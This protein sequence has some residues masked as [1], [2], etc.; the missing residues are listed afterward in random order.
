MHFVRVVLSVDIHNRTQCPGSGSWKTRKLQ[1]RQN[2]KRFLPAL[3][4]S[5]VPEG[6]CFRRAL[7]FSEDI[8]TAQD[9]AFPFEHDEFDQ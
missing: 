8:Q 9:T 1:S 7:L 2:S 5:A 6:K 4:G 3:D